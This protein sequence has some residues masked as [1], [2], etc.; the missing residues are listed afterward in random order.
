MNEPPRLGAKDRSSDVRWLVRLARRRTR[1][2]DRQL[3]LRPLAVSLLGLT[4]AQ[5]VFFVVWGVILFPGGS[6]LVKLTWMLLVCGIGMGATLGVAI[7]L[8]I[9]GRWD[10]LRAILATMALTVVLLGVGCNLLCFTLDRHVLHMFSAAGAAR[11]FLVGG[12][13]TSAMGGLAIGTLLYTETGR[14]I[15]RAVGL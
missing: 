8:I 5:L 11:G 12:F 2:E 14:R 15:L 9:S 1:E 6:L 13:T 10:G 3:Y 4:T 7:D